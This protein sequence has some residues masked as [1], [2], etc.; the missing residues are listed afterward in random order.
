MRKHPIGQPCP[1][2]IVGE[3]IFVFQKRKKIQLSK[4]I[5]Y[6]TFRFQCFVFCIFCIN[7][8]NRKKLSQNCSE[9]ESAGN[10][11]LL[12]QTFIPPQKVPHN[13]A[14]EESVCAHKHF[15]HVKQ[16]TTSNLYNLFVFLHCQMSLCPRSNVL[17]DTNIHPYVNITALLL[18]G[19]IFLP[20]Q[21][22]ICI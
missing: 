21:I 2:Q 9:T 10:K 17:S 3:G 11:T 13:C 18:R 6:T 4:G 1:Q 15:N 19:W 20:G 7:Y 8:K 14:G 22:M 5:R 16:L 12:T